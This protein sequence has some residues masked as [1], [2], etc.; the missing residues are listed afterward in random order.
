MTRVLEKNLL[1]SLHFQ[2]FA[3]FVFYWSLVFIF[4]LPADI[5]VRVNR[6]GGLYDNGRAIPTLVRETESLIYLITGWVNAPLH[7]KWEQVILSSET[8]WEIMIKP[9]HRFGCHGAPFQIRKSTPQFLSTSTFKST[10]SQ[11]F[12]APK[13][14]KDC[15]SMDLCIQLT[16]HL[17]LKLTGASAKI[18]WWLIKNW[19]FLLWK[20]KNLQL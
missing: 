4:R 1:A 15:Y 11:A 18:W 8:L 2:N 14:S 5:Q 17:Y 20:R 3:S 19:L 9:V 13:F 7:E 10:W 16:F 12:T 6:N